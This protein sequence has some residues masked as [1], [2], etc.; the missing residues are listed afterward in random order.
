MKSYHFV[1]FSIFAS[2]ASCSTFK[3]NLCMLSG[4]FSAMY[5]SFNKY[6]SGRR[7]L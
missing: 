6:G 4:V 7:K 3:Q 5:F 1:S 2:M